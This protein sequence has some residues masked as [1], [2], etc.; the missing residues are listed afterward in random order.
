[1]TRA[2]P[3]VVGVRV[4]SWT[5]GLMWRPHSTVVRAAVGSEQ[6]RVKAAQSRPASLRQ[7]ARYL[8]V[9][10]TIYSPFWSALVKLH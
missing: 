1:M 8:A 4:E 10:K 5:D 6:G 2:H 7:P 3:N 9:K